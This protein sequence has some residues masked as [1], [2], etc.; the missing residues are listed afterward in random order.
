MMQNSTRLFVDGA[1]FSGECKLLLVKRR[2][3]TWELPS[4]PLDFGEEP[5]VGVSRIFAELTGIDVTP[6]RPLGSWGLIETHGE[7]RAHIVHIGYTVTLAGTLLAV[8]LDTEKHMSFAWLNQNELA[9]K[10]E[11]P[12]LLR[13]CERAFTALARPRKNKQ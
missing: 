4:E 9:A 5:E 11:S 12:P 6:D 1:L 7:E 2:D 13:L 10:I 8:E 3:G